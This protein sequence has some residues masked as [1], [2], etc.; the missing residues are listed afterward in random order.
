MNERS[1]VVRRLSK[2]IQENRVTD[3][4]ILSVAIENRKRKLATSITN[5]KNSSYL[6]KRKK[7]NQEICNPSATLD[8]ENVNTAMVNVLSYPASPYKA[9]SGFYEVQYLKEKKKQ[10][11][12]SELIPAVSTEPDYEKETSVSSFDD[13]SQ[14][15]IDDAESNDV[16]NRDPVSSHIT[17]ITVPDYEDCSILPLQSSIL[18]S[19]NSSSSSSSSSSTSLSEKLSLSSLRALMLDHLLSILNGGSYEE[20]LSLKG[21]GQ[22]RTMKIFTRRNAG[23]AFD[24]LDDLERIGMNAKNIERF[25][26]ANCGSLVGKI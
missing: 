23:K 18:P 4:D 2:G 10:L 12:K 15:L 9:L 25:V 5:V 19:T 26:I 1:E 6:D 17:E 16:I 13:S 7:F 3:A 8:K 21:I 11:A 24:C 20:L 14:T 22:V